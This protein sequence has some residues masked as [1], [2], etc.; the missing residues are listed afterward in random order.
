MYRYWSVVQQ[1]R[2]SHYECG[3]GAAAWLALDRGMTQPNAADGPQMGPSAVCLR[4]LQHIAAVIWPYSKDENKAT[5][6]Q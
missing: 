4:E 5:R 6:N 3:T 2:N 1:W